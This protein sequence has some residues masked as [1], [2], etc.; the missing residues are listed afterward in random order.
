MPRIAKEIAIYGNCFSV[1][2]IGP[3]GKIPE[4]AHRGRDVYGFRDGHGLTVVQRF[5]SGQLVGVL[6]NQISE[7][8]KQTSPLRCG[9]LA[10]RSVFECPPGSIDRLIHIG[11][12]GF[13]NLAD[14]FAG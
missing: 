12:I 8:V 9:N 11:C 2:F 7:P 10:P 4:A 3:A 6:F 1:N 13:G 5:E 14:F